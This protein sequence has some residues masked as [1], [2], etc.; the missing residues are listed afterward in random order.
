M[1]NQVWVKELGI[2]EEM[3]EQWGKAMDNILLYL[4]NT[5]PGKPNPEEL[6]LSGR[7]IGKLP[8]GLFHIVMTD[9]LTDVSMALC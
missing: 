7:T 3:A 8:E 6:S 2:F 1:H 9:A 5:L 4:L